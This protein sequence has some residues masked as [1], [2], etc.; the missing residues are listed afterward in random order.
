[1]SLLRLLSQ[2]YPL[3]SFPEAMKRDVFFGLFLSLFLVV[4]TPFGLDVFAYDRFYIILGYGLISYLTI[5]LNDLIGYNLAPRVFSEPDWKVYHQIAWGVWH[6]FLLGVGN[7]IYGFLVGAFPLTLYSFLKIELYVL[8]CSIIPVMGITILRQNYLLKQNTNRAED[9]NRD[10]QEGKS[11]PAEPV[12][13]LIRFAAE[14]S[15][16]YF[17]VNLS[18]IISI[19]SQDNYVEFVFKNGNKVQKELLRSTLGNIEEVL[20]GNPGFFRCHRAY[21]INLNK[22]ELVFG[23]SQGYRIKMEGLSEP[24]PVAR[25]RNRALKDL[26][27]Y[28]KREEA[29]IQQ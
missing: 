4:F 22:I 25:P 18:S 10:I 5:A 11:H 28:L 29:A 23:N 3:F 9:I 20:S 19:S 1:M 15:K 26:I 24:I 27:Q 8:A 13:R 12:D 14:N 16:N 17:E 7:L 21:I 2:P 6:L